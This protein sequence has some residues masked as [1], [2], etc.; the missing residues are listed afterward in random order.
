MPRP[1]FPD[2]SLTPSLARLMAGG[3][4]RVCGARPWTR[5]TVAVP[6]CNAIQQR[7]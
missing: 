7:A 1:G 2:N 3:G 5:R 6:P 4:V